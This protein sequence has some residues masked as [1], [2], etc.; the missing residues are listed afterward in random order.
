MRRSLSLLLGLA[1]F[2]AASAALAQGVDTEIK[3]LPLQNSDTFFI[4]ISIH[5]TAPNPPFAG[6]A[7]AIMKLH[8]LDNTELDVDAFHALL[9]WRAIGPGGTTFAG[10]GPVSVPIASPLGPRSQN[11]QSAPAY[12]TFWHPNAQNSGIPVQPSVNLPLATGFFHVKGSSP[13]GN[14]DV[15]ATFMFWNIW[16]ILG[17]GPGSTL[18]QLD[19]SDR[20]WV[21]SNIQDIGQLQTSQSF[22]GF[23]PNHP[24]PFDPNAHWLHITNP[25]TFHL[26]G[27]AG[28][29]FYATFLNTATLG[30]EHVPEPA[31]AALIGLGL[32]AI[33]ASRAARRQRLAAA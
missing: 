7:G 21:T 20:V 6:W 16:H 23:Q 14:S 24:T 25:V 29:A 18:L 10:P 15:D 31:S 22:F 3:T 9:P 2:L 5:N 26:T 1:L 12:V 13:A 32:V 17:G 4:P 33:A 27:F 19:V 30:V 11:V 28:S 8:L